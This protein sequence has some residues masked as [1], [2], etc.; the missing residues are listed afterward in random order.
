MDI[1]E[2]RQA[3]LQQAEAAYVSEQEALYSLLQADVLEDIR[4]IDAERWG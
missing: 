4:G 1:I 2:V 3:E